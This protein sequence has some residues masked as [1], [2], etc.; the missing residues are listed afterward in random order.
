MPDRSLDVW[1]FSERV[2][3]LDQTAGR[4]A[5]TYDSGWLVHPDAMPLS[6]SLPLQEKPF[7]DRAARP[8]FAGLLPEQDRR[9]QAARA[10]GVSERNDFALLDALGGECAGAIS[11][12]HRGE[13]LVQ[14][15]TELDYRTL[16]DRD[17]ASTDHQDD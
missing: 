7:E 3:R 11:F 9:G 1:L 6:A 5:F 12:T 16:D 13:K 14:E 8:F 4:L 17:L 2:G 10:I 15:A